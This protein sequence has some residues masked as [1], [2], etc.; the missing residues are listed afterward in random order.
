MV[1]DEIVVQIKGKARAK[2]M[3]AKDLSCEELQQIALAD[4]KVEAEIDG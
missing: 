2:L 1:E 3:V 4:E